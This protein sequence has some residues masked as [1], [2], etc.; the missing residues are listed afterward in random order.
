MITFENISKQYV[1]DAQTITAVSDVNLTIK[2]GE[3]FG[4]IGYSGAGKSTLLRMINGLEQPTQGSVVVDGAALQTLTANELRAQRQKIGMIFQHFNLLWSRTVSDNIALA[5]EVAKTPKAEIATRVAELIQ[6]VGLEGR[7]N[8]YPSQLSGGQKQRVGIARALAN[9]PQILL[10]DEATSAL[11]PETTEAILALL[12]DINQ[13][14]GITIVFITHEMQVVKNLAHRVAVMEAGRVVELG[15]VLTIFQNP[16]QAITKRFVGEA[17]TESDYELTLDEL[18]HKYPKGQVWTLHFVKGDVEKPILATAMKRFDV[19]F[20][21][22]QG[23]IAKTKEGSVGQLTVLVQADE[24][25][26]LAAVKTYIEQQAVTV[27]EV[28]H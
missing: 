16:Q 28:Q 23:S 24:V 1:K 20:S 9:N 4:I 6:L 8:N 5:L 26:K 11:D 14:L 15:D 27:Q 10:A 25:N 12:T 3:I 2:A 21:I 22:I 13:K 17:T 19:E 18:A 7:E